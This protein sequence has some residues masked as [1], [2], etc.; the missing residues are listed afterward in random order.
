MET[1]QLGKTSHE[2]IFHTYPY[3]GILL[4]WHRCQQMWSCSQFSGESGGGCDWMAFA[5]V[6]HTTQWKHLRT[7]IR[8][9]GMFRNMA[10]S[11]LCCEEDFKVLAA[12]ECGMLGDLV[13][14]AVQGLPSGLDE[15]VVETLHHAFHHK[16]LRQW[17]NTHSRQQHVGVFLD[18]GLNR[19]QKMGRHVR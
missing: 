13:Q 18:D 19:K 11:N 15:V 2:G 17:L 8:R 5:N 16:L 14:E 12:G 9:C 1:V 3:G 6:L 7:A 4:K 10:D